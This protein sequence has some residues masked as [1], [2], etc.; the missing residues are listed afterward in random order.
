MDIGVGM[1]TWTVLTTCSIRVRFP[2]AP[3]LSKQ[4]VLL[5]KKDFFVDSFDSFIILN[6]LH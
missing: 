3:P 5:K 1:V 2:G 4:K 6:F